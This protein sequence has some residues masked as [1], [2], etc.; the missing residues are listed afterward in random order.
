MRSG[1][2]GSEPS[3]SGIETL[4]QMRTRKK[5]STINTA[6][7]PPQLEISGLPDRRPAGI[8]VASEVIARVEPVERLTEVIAAE[9]RRVEE[10]WKADPVRL[11]EERDDLKKIKVLIQ[12]N[13]D[14][15]RDSSL[16]RLGR[17]TS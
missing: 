6:T 17:A 15:S 13:D 16:A 7:D 10:E 2:A 1:A 4:T 8:L 14:Q 5:G 3:F 9:T 11:K 12:V